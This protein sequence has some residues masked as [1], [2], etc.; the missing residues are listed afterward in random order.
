M[1]IFGNIV[2]RDAD[3]TDFKAAEKVVDPRLMMLLKP[4][5]G[6]KRFYSLGFKR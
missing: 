3:D 4:M 5:G 6:F 2:Q 1:G